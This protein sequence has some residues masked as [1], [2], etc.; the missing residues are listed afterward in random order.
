LNVVR[1]L[2]EHL[3]IGHQLLALDLDQ[4]NATFR[5]FDEVGLISLDGAAARHGV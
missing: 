4:K 2:V 3:I 1:A 5:T